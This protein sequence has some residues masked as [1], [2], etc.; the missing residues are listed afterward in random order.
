[1][2]YTLRKLTDPTPEELEEI[3]AIFDIAFA[4]ERA[5]QS[6]VGPEKFPQILPIL[7]RAQLIAGSLGGEI[8]I[9][10]DAANSNKIIGAI[11]WF[12]PG[13]EIYDSDEQR[14]RALGPLMEVFPPEAKQW[15][16]EVT[17]KMEAFKKASFGDRARTEWYLQRVGVLP[18]W[19]GKGVG[20]ALIEEGR[21][22]VGKHGIALQAVEPKNVSYY[23]YLGFKNKGHI[24]V[25]A[26]HGDFTVTSLFWEP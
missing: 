13:R 17:P 16:A 10:A 8:I 11:I 12:G 5:F 14:K 22:R 25:Q 20:T 24:D 19:Q 2:N 3:R 18:D 23:E 4:S 1:M 7:N 15:Y 9:A 26:L 6:V 21:K